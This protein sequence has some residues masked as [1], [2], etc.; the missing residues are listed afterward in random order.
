[1]KNVFFAL[2]DSTR[3]EIL[4]YLNEG[5]MTAGEIADKFD[6]SKPSISHHLNI[7]KEAG[8]VTVEKQGQFMRY[9]INTTVFED[10]ASW[11]ISM[12]GGRKR[13]AR[14]D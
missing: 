2:S 3:R 4:E 10:V 7:L 1:M 14:R 13:H 5:D 12:M 8:L 11:V 6:I 9:S